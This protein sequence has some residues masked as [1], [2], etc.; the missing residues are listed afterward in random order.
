MNWR[1][2]TLGILTIVAALAGAGKTFLA[3]GQIPDLT[4][5]VAAVMAG[6]GLVAARDAKN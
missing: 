4:A 3:T 1:T 6:I 5:V 2:S